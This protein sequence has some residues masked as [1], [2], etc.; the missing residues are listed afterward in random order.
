MSNKIT[1]W[2]CAN[3]GN[4][5]IDKVDACSVNCKNPNV[6]SE[7]T[8]PIS[9]IEDAWT[10]W[11]TKEGQ[12]VRVDMKGSQPWECYLFATLGEDSKYRHLKL[13]KYIS[14]KIRENFLKPS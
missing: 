12:V 14:K 11:N 10:G 6:V 13:W 9:E 3:C 2:V 4:T 5:H 8:L 7:V 1:L